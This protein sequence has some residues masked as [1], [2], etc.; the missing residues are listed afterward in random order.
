MADNWYVGNANT[1]GEDR[2]G[3]L[4]G[5]FI[6]DT[7]DIR[8]TKDVEIKWGVHPAGEERVGWTTDDYRTT[9][10]ILVR[11]RF[12]ISLPSDSFILEHEG[13]YVMW[14][15]G[16][17]HSWRAERDSVVLTVRWPSSAA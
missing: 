6:D 17:N 8:A 14:A 5:H 9:V 1:D 15:A 3:W 16:I 11:G 2:R 7:D 10:V 4:I 13:D 12:R